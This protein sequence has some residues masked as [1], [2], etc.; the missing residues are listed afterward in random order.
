MH[1]GREHKHGKDGWCA[2]NLDRHRRKFM[3]APGTSLDGAF[4]AR[5]GSLTFW[6]E[7]EAPSR[8]ITRW[9]PQ[10]DMP[11]YL[12][13]PCFPGPA[14]AFPQLQN[15]DPYVF[16]DRFRY[17]L[18]KQVNKLGRPTFLTS[19]RPGT[20]VLF[21]SHD[22]GRFLL[23]TVFVVDDDIVKHSL[24][25]WQT[26][27]SD[28]G[29]IYRHATLEPMYW[30]TNIKPE[31]TYSLYFGARAV[32][33]TDRVFSYFPCQE[34]DHPSSRFSRPVLHLPDI[35]NSRMTMGQKKIEMTVSE[36]RQVWQLVTTQVIDHGLRLG[37]QADEPARVA[38][39]D[40]L[41]PH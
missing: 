34:L 3:S 9:T 28:L 5:R 17:T 7:W 41:W 27:L 39:P 25:T 40:H 18:C 21:G 16:G 13:Q 1:P 14:T 15:T 35:L 37:V 11:T 31:S 8:V 32:A 29:D 36:I 38:V 2:W 10:P 4:A 33:G 26:Q 22:D 24:N 20:L 19:L 23:D 12:V 30:D 6:G